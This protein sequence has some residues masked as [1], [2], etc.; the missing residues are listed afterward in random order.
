MIPILMML[1]LQQSAPQLAR[2]DSLMQRI[3][4]QVP[5]LAFGVT[6]VRADEV[7]HLKTYG[8]D[9]SGQP[10]TAQSPFYIASSTKSFTALVAA[11]LA[12]RRQ[13][14]LDVP[15]SRYVP[16]FTL[17]SPLDASRVT[18]R[19]LLSHRGGFESG[20]VGTRTAFTGNLATDSMLPL[21]M[22]TAMPVDTGFR[23]TN[24][25][26]I[27]A[28]RVMELVT[29]TPW[30]DLVA[31]EILRP[32]GMTRS[33]ARLSEAAAWP[34][35]QGYSPGPEG[36]RPI[37]Q[38]SDAIMH[39]AGGMVMSTSDAA[40]WLRFQLGK[41]RLDGRQIVPERIV[42]ATRAQAASQRDSFETIDRFGYGLGWQI[43]M[44]HGD[45]LLHHFGNYPGAFA[46]VSFMPARGVGVA[47]FQNS[48][49]PAH[50]RIAGLIARYA[51]DLVIGGDPARLAAAERE[52]DSLASRTAR[53]TAIFR[54]DWA[55]R[56]ARGTTPPR[57][58]APYAGSYVNPDWGT[59]EIIAFQ[60]S[61]RLRFGVVETPIQLFQG[62]DIRLEM[63]AGRTSGVVARPTFG[64]DGRV[65]QLSVDGLVFVPR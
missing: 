11:I 60:D 12:D 43:G 16:G 27:L 10:L 64:E 40:R 21:L 28:A 45:T 19:R 58:W 2:L 7:L 35:A 9:T 53:M 15:I 50:G 25:Q 22:R 20:P 42:M 62:D 65:T 56:A 46:H 55:R 59:L 14:D 30:Q 49:M 52:V 38:K 23:Y 61:A 17:P 44:W 36:T 31:R 51:Y 4:A 8:N 63:T 3:S 5:Y 47:V 6:V 34:A 57:G 48:E 18:L 13:I 41:G 54:N 29:G 33:T 24:T 32:L 1:S 26:F 37:G 39:A